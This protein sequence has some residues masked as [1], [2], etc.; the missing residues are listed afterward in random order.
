MKIYNYGS[1]EI[2][3]SEDTVVVSRAHFETLLLQHSMTWHKHLKEGIF[4][5]QAD[6]AEKIKDEIDK[7]FYDLIG[8]SNARREAERAQMDIPF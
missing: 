1:E 7:V 5:D 8:D 2:V 3:V 4:G 6:V